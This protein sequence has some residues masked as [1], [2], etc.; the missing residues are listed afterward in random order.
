M[1]T[2]QGICQLGEKGKC[3]RGPIVTNCSLGPQV[4]FCSCEQCIF[5]SASNGGEAQKRVTYREEHK[6]TNVFPVGFQSLATVVPSSPCHCGRMFCSPSS[7]GRTM[8]TL[9]SEQRATPLSVKAT[10][11]W[12][13]RKVCVPAKRAFRTIRREVYLQSFPT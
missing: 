2:E 1:R 6:K 4:R 8:D 5:Y 7:C 9:S 11:R 3:P 13:D 12:R 10:A